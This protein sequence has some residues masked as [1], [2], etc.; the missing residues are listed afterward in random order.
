MK[1]VVSFSQIYIFVKK[2]LHS[3][4]EIYENFFLMRFLFWACD[5][6]TEDE[7]QRIAAIL[8]YMSFN[9]HIWLHAS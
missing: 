2:N 5:V 3:R 6:Q 4:S 7:S 1:I 8:A 9:D